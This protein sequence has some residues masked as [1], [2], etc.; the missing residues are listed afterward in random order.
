M[1][2]VLVAVNDLMFRSK[3]REAASASGVEI[4]FARDGDA[5]LEAARRSAPSQVLV[6]LADSRLDAPG[7]VRRLKAEAS[8]AGV[9]VV[10]FY[11]HVREDL[12]EAAL[13]AGFDAAV[14]RSAFAARLRAVLEGTYPARGKRDVP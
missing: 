14:P 4:E 3:I 10:G 11:P 9:P 1:A 7:V 12:S 13:A 6:D 5:L 8:L 2:K